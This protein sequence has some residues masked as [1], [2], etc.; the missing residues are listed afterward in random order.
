MDAP[1]RKKPYRDKPSPGKAMPP[2]SVKKKVAKKKVAKPVTKK[3][4]KGY[5]PSDEP[6]PAFGGMSQNE[7]YKQTQKDKKKKKDAA[8]SE[9]QID[10]GGAFGPKDEE[11]ADFKDFLSKHGG[12]KG[13]QFNLIGK[14]KTKE[15]GMKRAREAYAEEQRES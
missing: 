10:K 12:V 2:A 14:N 13:F 4:Q 11:T 9:A 7:F 6:S 5:I 15:A 1:G 3:R 8:P